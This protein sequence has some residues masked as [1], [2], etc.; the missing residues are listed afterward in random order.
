MNLPT[1]PCSFETFPSYL[2]SATTQ[3]AVTEALGPFL[4]YE[5]KLRQIFA[6]EPN[7]PAVSEDHLVP[8]FRDGVSNFTIRARDL[9]AESPAEKEKYLLPLSKKQRRENGAHA[10]AT[11]LK[12]FQNNFAL[13][14]EQAL[15][16]LKWDNVVVSGSGVLTALLPVEAPHNASKVSYQIVP[17]TM[18]TYIIESTAIVLPRATSPSFRR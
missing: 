4:D 8:V 15:A 12:E 9:D 17:Y 7:H 14:S 10:A 16:D 6:Q 2:Q 11:T 18:L 13:F 1:L 3:K 5:A